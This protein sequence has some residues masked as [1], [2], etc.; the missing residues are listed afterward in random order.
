MYEKYFVLFIE[1]D[2]MGNGSS[3]LS[4]T[5]PSTILQMCCY[6]QSI[7]TSF[8]PLFNTVM[9]YAH[10]KHKS[11]IVSPIYFGYLGTT[12]VPC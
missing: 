4:C 8:L 12:R 5:T 7:N 2:D 6:Q 11:C 9:D 1:D 10:K 3:E